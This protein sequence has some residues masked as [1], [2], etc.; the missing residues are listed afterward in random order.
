MYC[1]ELAGRID[2][3]LGMGVD[4][5][6]CQIVLHGVQKLPQIGEL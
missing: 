2:L 4:L 3:L 5:G 6:Q 1:G